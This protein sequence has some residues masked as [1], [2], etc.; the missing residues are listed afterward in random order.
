MACKQMVKSH[1]CTNSV[2][3]D[4]IRRAQEDKGIRDG[5]WEVNS[6]PNAIAFDSNFALNKICVYV[7]HAGRSRDLTWQI[8]V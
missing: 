7:H 2:V 5:A 3:P 4:E 6:N 8:V 1:L